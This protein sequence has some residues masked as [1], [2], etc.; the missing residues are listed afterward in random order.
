VSYKTA[1][2]QLSQA[3]KAVQIIRAAPA[4]SIGK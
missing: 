3:A 1:F 4:I 2:A